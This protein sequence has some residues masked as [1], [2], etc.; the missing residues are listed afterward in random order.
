[1]PTNALYCAI[2]GYVLQIIGCAFYASRRG[3]SALFG[4]LG[5]LSPIGYVFLALLN[6]AVPEDPSER[7]LPTGRP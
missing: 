6:P 1:V 7:Q 4:F 5:L 2:A 3:R